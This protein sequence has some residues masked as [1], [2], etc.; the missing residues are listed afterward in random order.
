M[1][2]TTQKV[3]FKTNQH[4][5]DLI[6]K[7]TERFKYTETEYLENLVQRSLNE[8]EHRIETENPSKVLAHYK[9]AMDFFKF[10]DA[11]IQ[12]VSLE[13]SIAL[14]IKL[15]AKEYEKDMTDLFT[16]FI[17]YSILRD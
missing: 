6:Q 9:D 11:H 3:P 5:M 8:F 17:C 4:L 16:M 1:T 7:G 15:T 13:R 10:N 14:T 12:K 2:Q